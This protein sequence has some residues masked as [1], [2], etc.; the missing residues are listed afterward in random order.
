MPETD[1]GLGE[2]FLL[3]HGAD[4]RYRPG[5]GWMHWDGRR[6]AWDGHGRAVRADMQMVVRAITELESDAL[7]A[8]SG[9]GRRRSAREQRRGWGRSCETPRR[10]ASALESAETLPGAAVDDVAWDADALA[11]NTRGG[12]LD[13]RTGVTTPH[14]RE[15]HCTGMIEANLDADATSDALEQVMAHLSADSPEVREFLARWLGYC[16]TGSIAAEAF[17]FMSGAPESGKST[18]LTA[19]TR[20]LGSY[21]EIASAESFTSRPPTGG[22]SPE[23]ARLAGKRFVYVPEAGGIRM[24][25]ARVKQIVGGD[26][27]VARML[28]KNPVTFKPQ[29]KLAFSANELAVIPDDDAGLRRRLLPLRVESSVGRRGARIKAALEDSDEGRSAILRLAVGGCHRWL[30]NGRDLDALAVPHHLG[31]EVLAYLGEMDP[32]REWWDERVRVVPGSST[33]TATL[34]T[35]YVAWARTHGVQRPLGIKGFAQR[36]TRRGF[37]VDDDRTHGSQRVGLDVASAGQAG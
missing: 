27:I 35:D 8:I 19:F 9:D 30:T 5:V 31:A 3:W 13:L 14:A 32:L 24:D 29:F 28:H 2:R 33:T 10:I 21:A 6:W 11:V 22:A 23:L 26:P 18:L 37:P 17:L 16:L 12:L 1:L 20:M 15:D 7:P 25:A 4:W 36:L 34:H